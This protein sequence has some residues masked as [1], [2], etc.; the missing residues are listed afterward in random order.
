[1]NSTVTK[2]IA[3]VLIG[4]VL[5]VIGSRVLFVGSWLSL[6]P[7]TIAGLLLGMWST[8]RQWT[9]I[10]ALF[11]FSVSFVFMVAGYAGAANLV[12]RFPF[13]AALGLFGAVCGIVLGLLGHLLRKA[14][15]IG[16]DST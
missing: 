13:F 2:S 14:L 4:S 3:A 9:W 5:G 10:G 8:K 15:R 6:V 11:G 1:V 16:G 7:W 12:S